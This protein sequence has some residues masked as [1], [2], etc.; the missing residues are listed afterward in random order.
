MADQN[1]FLKTFPK[2][3]LFEIMKKVYIKKRDPHLINNYSTKMRGILK[4]NCIYMN[5]IF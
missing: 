3:I 1:I 5:K 2:L 4:I